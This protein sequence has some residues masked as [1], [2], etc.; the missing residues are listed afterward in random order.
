MT[1][2]FAIVGYAARFPGAADADEFWDVLRQ[3][4]DAVSEIP[5]DRWNLDE[6]YDPDPDAPGKFV[7][8]RAGLIENIDDFDAPFFG[9][10]P[11]EAVFMDPQ[12]RILLETSWQALEHS[13]L[14]PRAL[15]GSRTGVF[16]GLSTHDYLGLMSHNL[17]SKTSR[18][19]SAP[20]PRLPP[21]SVASAIASASKAPPSRSTRPAAPHWSRCT[22]PP[23]AE[24]R[25]V[26]PG[27]G[28]RRQRPAQPGDDDQLLPGTHAGA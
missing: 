15:A 9:V 16:M 4:R 27:A 20:A 24:G 1:N 5:S 26:Q 21:R 25:R 8:R 22:R 19:T 2:G 6:F 18:P 7:T 10:S 17:A 14:R 23:G 12:H 13:G 3:G 11:R 28:R